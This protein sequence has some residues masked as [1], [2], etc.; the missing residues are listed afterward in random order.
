MHSAPLLDPVRNPLGVAVVVNAGGTAGFAGT[1]TLFPHQSIVLRA[2][3]LA[4]GDGDST[5][6][7]GC[8][9]ASRVV[10]VEATH[11]VGVHAVDA[12]FGIGRVEIIMQVLFF[13]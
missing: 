9:V 7:P 10:A 11:D 4:D 5:A 13:K 3:V 1:A 12:R 2:G 6:R 8:G